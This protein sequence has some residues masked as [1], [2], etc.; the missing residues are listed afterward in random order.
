[1]PLRTTLDRD[2]PEIAHNGPVP[3]TEL[4]PAGLR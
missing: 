2:E 3:S 1:V 4:D